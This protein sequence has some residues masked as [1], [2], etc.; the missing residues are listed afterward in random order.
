MKKIERSMSALVLACIVAATVHPATNAAS[1]PACVSSITK[2]S[3]PRRSSLPKPSLQEV[4][5]IPVLYATDREDPFER[6]SR[7]PHPPG[8]LKTGTAFVELVVPKQQQAAPPALALGQPKSMVTTE[9]HI[10]L[11]GYECPPEALPPSGVKAGLPA[12][13]YDE[14]NRRALQCLP[15]GRVYLYVDGYGEQFK[16]IVYSAALLESITHAP[17]I[18]FVW[19]SVGSVQLGWKARHG[20]DKPREDFPMESFLD[21][22]DG[23]EADYAMIQNSD[24]QRHLRE[25]ITGLLDKLGDSNKLTVV[26]HSLGNK[27]LI[28]TLTSTDTHLKSKIDTIAFVAADVPE[29]RFCSDWPKLRECCNH[30]WILFN[31]DDRALAFAQSGA[32]HLCRKKTDECAEL[33]EP[34]VGRI[35]FPIDDASLHQIDY[36]PLARP[37]GGLTMIQHFIPF[38]ALVQLLNNDVVPARDGF[39]VSNVSRVIANESER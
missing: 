10:Y 21:A 1:E 5:T 13:F 28:D 9:P 38:P 16:D 15:A 22:V 3:P 12:D 32:E 36:S 26:A 25:V 7:H 37:T 17:V 2:D 11:R 18:A 35:G 31:P 39:H 20:K 14:V 4:I 29:G 8:E 27:L 23:Y 30:P 6:P 34:R 24:V 19:P 33:K